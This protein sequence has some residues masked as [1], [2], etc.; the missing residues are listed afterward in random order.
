MAKQKAT[1]KAVA[2]TAVKKK[3]TGLGTAAK[4][5]ARKTIASKGRVAT[6][7]SKAAAKPAAKAV[8][9]P[10]ARPKQRIAISHHRDEDFK[11][12]GLRT[13]AQ[14]RDLGIAAA[15]H[16]LAQAHVIRLIGPCNPEEVSKLHY[17]D[18]EFQ[19]VYVLKGW[20]KTYMEGQGETLMKEGGCWTQPPR[21]RHLILDYS[22][23]V[24]LL[25]VI[26]PAEFKTV[27]LGA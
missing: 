2:K 1:S 10:K 14:Y 22:D 24:E 3:W 9:K 7:K 21:I 26:L 4:S 6:A 20:V 8:A 18:V 19:M 12:D 13:Y 5:T 23:D 27:E 25:E 16:G 11:A 15:T 17:H